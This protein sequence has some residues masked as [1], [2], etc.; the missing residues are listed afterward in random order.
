MSTTSARRS[1][2]YTMR[3]PEEEREKEQEIIDRLSDPVRGV[4]LPKTS[5]M[6]TESP[7]MEQAKEKFQ[8]REERKARSRGVQGRGQGVAAVDATPSRPGTSRSRSPGAP[9]PGQ[10]P[11]K[12]R[13]QDSDS[14][15]SDSESSEIERVMASRDKSEGEESDVEYFSVSMSFAKLRSH[16]VRVHTHVTQLSEAD[17]EFYAV[18]FNQK[19]YLGELR[20]VFSDDVDEPNHSAELKFLEHDMVQNCFI[21][22]KRVDIENVNVRKLYFGPMK[23]IRRGGVNDPKVPWARTGEEKIKFPELENVKYAWCAYKRY[24]DQIV[25]D[26]SWEPPGAK[27]DNDP[28]SGSTDAASASADV[29]SGSA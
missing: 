13:K 25:R 8:R 4:K 28:K 16:L 3:T 2:S 21:W 22:P 12:M 6:M 1:L 10:P 15:D 9:Q 29:A 27:N 5:E 19:V 20:K 23:G 17:K 18:Y 11:A 24:L 7:F 14:S 26:D